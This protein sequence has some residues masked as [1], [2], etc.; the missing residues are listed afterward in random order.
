MADGCVR[1]LLAKRGSAVADP[2]YGHHGGVPYEAG[3]YCVLLQPLDTSVPRFYGVQRDSATGETTLWIDY[4]ENAT[5]LKSTVPPPLV[6]AARWAAA[7][8]R[9]NE[10][11]AS[12]LEGAI[13]IYDV[14]YYLGWM[15][16]SLEFSPAWHGPWLRALSRHF[17]ALAEE[18]AAA[19]I[20]TIHGEYYPENILAHDGVI[21]PIDWES[22]AIAMGEIDLASLTEDWSPEDNMA[23]QLAYRRSRW[24]EGAPDEFERRLTLARLYLMFRWLGDRSEWVTGERAEGQFANLRRLAE[25][26]GV[27]SA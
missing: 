7:F 19:P 2:A 20:T 1:K 22:A 8:H 13:N 23:C 17:E 18:I 16:R 12:G 14:P 4:L 26:L 10:S 21:A 9:L 15:R 5:R 6:E 25:Q 11:R 27:L 3:V 24:P